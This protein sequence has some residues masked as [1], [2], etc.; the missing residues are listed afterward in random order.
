MTIGLRLTDQD[1]ADWLRTHEANKQAIVAEMKEL[2]K[3]VITPP[4]IAGRAMI[5]LVGEWIGDRYRSKDDA[6]I[7]EAAHI[8]F[9]VDARGWPY[10][11]VLDFLHRQEEFQAAGK[12]GGLSL[13]WDEPD[14][15][16]ADTPVRREDLLNW[17][18]RRVL[19]SF[20][21]DDQWTNKE[22]S[23]LSSACVAELICKLDTE[24]RRLKAG[25]QF[26]DEQVLERLKDVEHISGLRDG[27]VETLQ[28]PSVGMHEGK[29]Y[30]SASG[31][32]TE[33]ELEVMLFV[34]RNHK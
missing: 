6:E 23:R 20:E 15:Y 9:E 7:I 27:G 19:R 16:R 28:M 29:A 3:V 17:E 14:Y 31:C 5:T 30:L 8:H 34:V 25:P 22:G 32:F 12:L 26:T 11:Q 13:V 33:S 21:S 24:R 10:Y 2:T 4:K 18:M 1:R